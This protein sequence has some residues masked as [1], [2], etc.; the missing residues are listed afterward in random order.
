MGGAAGGRQERGVAARLLQKEVVDV[1]L[2]VAARDPQPAPKRAFELHL[3]LVFKFP[4][5][6]IT[7]TT[8]HLDFEV[9]VGIVD[10]HT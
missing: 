8:S 5:A 4:V 10:E 3:N 2:G 7:W 6:G 1:I 9:A